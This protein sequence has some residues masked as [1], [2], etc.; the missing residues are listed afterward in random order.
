MSCL[1]S[2]LKN[3]AAALQQMLYSV[4]CITECSVKTFK[5]LNIAEWNRA[6]PSKRK[7][8]ANYRGTNRSQHDA[9]FVE[10]L[11]SVK[12]KAGGPQ[13]QAPSSPQKDYDGITFHSS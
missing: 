2:S 5:M 8:Q 13:T 10:P 12:E 11:K 7:Y 4:A 9:T 3:V 1:W 6:W